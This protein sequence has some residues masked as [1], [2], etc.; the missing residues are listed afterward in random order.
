MAATKYQVMYRYMNDI[1]NVPITNNQ[2][3]TYE[4]VFEFYT[5]PDHRIFD[6]DQDIQNA[7]LEKQQEMISFANQSSNPKNDMLFVYNGCKKVQH[8]V[9]V[10]ERLGYVV[11]NFTPIRAKIGNRGDWSKE[12]YCLNAE[13]PE[14]GGLVICTE[15]VFKNYFTAKTVCT[16]GSYTS[17]E[18]QK[19]LE[20]ATIFKLRLPD[21][22]DHAVKNNNYTQI[23]N[24]P[25]V[26]AY[27]SGYGWD[28]YQQGN[29]IA[30]NF[31]GPIYVD[32]STEIAEINGYWYRSNTYTE[33][34]PY[35]PNGED[36]YTSVSFSASDVET[37]MI[38]GHYEDAADAPYAIKDQYRRIESSPW[39][40]NCTVGS[41]EAALEKAKKLIEM[42]GIEN[43]KVIKLVAIDQ[44]IK[45]K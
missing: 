14:D 13:T 21:W 12:F 20:D 40:V 34:I 29:M 22:K 8:K 38:P 33:K 35:H 2:D 18:M 23:W 19:M 28:Y 42:I 5:D 17:D 24:G 32:D 15:E 26:Y 10:P 27:R 37:E 7:E 45:I 39:L 44:F 4:P 30:Q 6:T 16:A 1:M 43:V 25:W 3:S 36:C 11:R 31:T 41:L 9:W